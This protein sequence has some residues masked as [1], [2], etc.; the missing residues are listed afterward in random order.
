[1]SLRLLSGLDTV[2]SIVLGANRSSSL[3]LTSDQLKSAS[4]SLGACAKAVDSG[5][6]S[7]SAS[8][9]TAL[10]CHAWEQPQRCA[11]LVQ[12]LAFALREVE[13]SLGSPDGSS[14][15]AL[16][17][18]RRK[19]SKRD[20]ERCID[21]IWS[22]STLVKTLIGVPNTRVSAAQ[23]ADLL[24]RTHTFQALSRLSAAITT[25][26]REERAPYAA[27]ALGAVA[28][29]VN[30]VLRLAMCAPDQPLPCGSGPP[31]CP[32]HQGSTSSSQRIASSS[33]T[34]T[35]TTTN[36]TSHR[37][38]GCA[39]AAQPMRLGEATWQALADSR[40]M[41]H[42]CRA[43]L[44]GSWNDGSMVLTTTSNCLSMLGMLAFVLGLHV[45]GPLA[46]PAILAARDAI[47][48]GP[49]LQYMLAADVVSQ[50]YR[51]GSEHL[52]GVPVRHL[53]P[54][55][56]FKPD[57]QEVILLL[58]MAC[59]SVPGPM[60]L[61]HELR[62]SKVAA[63]RACVWHLRMVLRDLGRPDGGG[64]DRQM[65][66]YCAVFML[67]AATDLLRAMRLG[68]ACGD[69]AAGREG[70][71]GRWPAQHTG[72]QGL[73]NAA[74]PGG[75][76]GRGGG[77]D[78]GGGMGGAQQPQAA[79][80]TWTPGRRLGQLLLEEWW[81]VAV[82]LVQQIMDTGLRLPSGVEAYTAEGVRGSERAV[83]HVAVAS[84]TLEL[85]A[86]DSLPPGER[87][88]CLLLGQ[89]PC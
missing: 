20:T 53:M 32:R 22:F 75:G 35:I 13:A 24:L 81:G 9:I 25:A 36:G 48:S 67:G 79:M 50:L 6:D 44:T 82:P 65:A 16:I 63:A 49:C 66:P 29:C 86:L 57:A 61:Q 17:G 2:V 68:P 47:L 28:A 56:V 62:H 42:L 55:K 74:M 18:S 43:V 89:L 14:T 77:G 76:S 80:E 12:L 1:M 26:L 40:L 34:T 7:P 88:L 8:S 30:N 3:G 4:E 59:V 69:S 73:G 45:N 38:A 10:G 83:V 71:V 87:A 78:R 5:P 85:T 72:H 39:A 37:D 58:H 21:C 15:S 64:R 23:L 11:A 46:R 41:E 52:Y 70:E 19:P 51:T 84:L 54:R 33:S 27:D 60:L 31:S